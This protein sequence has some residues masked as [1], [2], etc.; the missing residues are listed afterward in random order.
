MFQYTPPVYLCH[1]VNTPKNGENTLSQ[2]NGENHTDTK[3]ENTTLSPKM[4]KSTLS[5]IM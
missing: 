3:T 2:E 1:D 5:Q 4:L